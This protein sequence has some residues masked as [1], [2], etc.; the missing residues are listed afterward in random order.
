MVYCGLR[1]EKTPAC[2]P[3][4]LLY[5]TQNVLQYRGYTA[6]RHTVYTASRHTVYKLTHLLTE[7][8]Q[9]KT[10]LPYMGILHK[11]PSLLVYAAA[12]LKHN[13][14]L[15]HL[16]R[17]Y[18]NLVRSHCQLHTPIYSESNEL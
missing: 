12:S 8:A 7:H 16:L 10:T 17:F 6:N 18:F 4:A 11:F 3:V 5:S 1:E 14:V 9:G 15:P 2:T 13:G